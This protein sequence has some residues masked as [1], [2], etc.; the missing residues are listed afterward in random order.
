MSAAVI[1]AT[2]TSTATE[3][4]SW[5]LRL[6][7]VAADY[8]STDSDDLPKFIEARPKSFGVDLKDIQSFNGGFEK[9]KVAHTGKVKEQLAVFGAYASNNDGLEPIGSALIT[10]HQ[11]YSGELKQMTDK[12]KDEGANKKT[13]KEKMQEGRKRAK[14]KSNEII[15][16]AFDAAEKVID[17]LPTNHQ[18]K[19]TDIWLSIVD[20]FLAFWNQ[21]LQWFQDIINAFKDW[22]E[23]VWDTVK[24]IWNNVDNV[25]G[26]V[27]DWFKALF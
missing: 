6:R 24:N 2:V 17:S 23:S 4:P 21:V 13:A 25:F 16:R 14:D 1:M 26:T 9:L 15:D 7:S 12:L 20:G 8:K 3:L 19:A 22:L 10:E 5:K 27:W 11:E 18:D